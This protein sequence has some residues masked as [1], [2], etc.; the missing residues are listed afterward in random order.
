MH[1]HASL[2]E[3]VEEIHDQVCSRCIERPPGGPPCEPLGKNCAL[4]LDLPS[5]LDAVHEVDSRTIEPYRDSVGRRV[6]THC[7][8]NGGD[9]CPCPANY[10]LVLVV[11]AI[12]TVD[13]RRKVWRDQEVICV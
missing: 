8:R 12:D 9:E 11:Q 4:E 6:C 10:L 3:Y 1:A 2:Q 5:L 13:Q 7:V